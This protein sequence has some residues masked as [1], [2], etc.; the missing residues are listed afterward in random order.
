MKS[1]FKI[2]LIVF[3]GG[4]VLIIGFFTFITYQTRSREKII[5]EQFHENGNIAIRKVEGYDCCEGFYTKTTLYDSN[6]RK[7][8][9]YGNQDGSRFK[10]ILKYKDSTVVFEGYYTI[11]NDSLENANNFDVKNS[12]LNS[13]SETEYYSNRELKSKKRLS[14]F[15][16]WNDRDTASLLIIKY[17]NTGMVTVNTEF[18]KDREYIKDENSGNYTQ[19]IQITIIEDKI[20]NY[21]DT[22]EIK[23]IKLE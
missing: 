8:E 12:M 10:E 4:L 17:D 20:K 3:L 19:L 16:K 6:G 18:R 14:Y 22:L 11:Y 23:K 2:I 1:I 9:T 5:D 13:L 15:E 7:I 21:V